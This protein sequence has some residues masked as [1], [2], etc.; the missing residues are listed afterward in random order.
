MLDTI[1]RENILP[2]VSPAHTDIEFL[3]VAGLKDDERIIKLTV[4]RVVI[5]IP[6]RVKAVERRGFKNGIYIRTCE[7]GSV[8]AEL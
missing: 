5:N 4:S 6:Y 3:V 1:T 8:H 2:S 7:G